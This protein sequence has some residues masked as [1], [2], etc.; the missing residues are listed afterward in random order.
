M[1]RFVVFSDL[2][3][4]LLDHYTYSF[5]PAR[6]ALDRL[7]R[8]GIP[9]VMVSSKTRRE[10]EILRQDMAVEDPFV[11]ENGGAIFIPE[12]AGLPTPAGA[13]K[14]DGYLVIVL[15]RPQDEL[16]RA[17]DA[18]SRDVP[19]RA[20]SRLAPREAAELTGLS[21]ERAA[22]AVAR[23]FGEALILDD[24][25]FPE[26]KL[27]QRVEALGL[28]LTK[29]GRFYHLL[30]ENDKGRAAAILADLYRR[31]WPDLVTA[32]VGDAPNDQALLAAA[33]RPFLVAGPDGRH[34]EVD[35][36]G[37]IKIPRPGPA[38]FARA[39]ETLLS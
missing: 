19:L 31:R 35:V 38:G 7:K 22:A 30:G 16:G 23:E 14:R 25:D 29:G 24:P 15:G 18:L 28:R 12:S 10:I 21:L 34:R 9:L 4:T 1:P 3:G 26:E 8:E 33:D 20:F 36:P 2:D 11:P 5:A 39:V 37:L 6:P 17:V 32:A 13:Q 27:R